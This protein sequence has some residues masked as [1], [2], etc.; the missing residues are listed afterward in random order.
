LLNEQVRELI[1]KLDLAVN[2]R[3]NE[4]IIEFKG[5]DLVNDFHGK[6]PIKWALKVVSHLFTNDE[7]ADNTLEASNRSTRGALS[8][9]RV[10]MLKEAMTIKFNL[11]SERADSVWICTLRSVNSKGRNIKH[12]INLMNRFK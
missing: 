12:R 2:A 6:N 5:K 4:K 3:R 10:K 11:N 1:S 9:A 7:L 8:P